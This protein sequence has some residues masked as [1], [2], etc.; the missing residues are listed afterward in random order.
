LRWARCRKLGWRDELLAAGNGDDVMP[1]GLRPETRRDTGEPGRLTVRTVPIA[2]P[3]DLL[4]ALPD[5]PLLSWVRRGRGLVGWGEAARVT[6]TAGEDRFTA[7]EKWLR[8]LFEDVIAEDQ[9]RVP[10]TGPVAFGSFTFDP[11]SDGSVLIVP[12]VIAGRDGT[13]TAWL[14]TISDG[15]EPAGRQSWPGAAGPDEEAGQPA[16]VRS[17]STLRWHDGSLTAPEW[18]HAV[19]LA[20]G[21]I[22]SGAL[23]KVVLARDVFATAA[24]PIDPRVLLRRL[25]ARYPDCYTFAVDG[26]TGA[27]PEL[28]IRRQG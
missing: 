18:E 11:A 26:L 9:V 21:R 27:T 19:E 12:R 14:T 1:G 10:G 23:R 8:T 13:G 3:G 2:D 7:G 4:A 24:E 5:G 25:A 17:A 6:L 22:T 16:G 15:R 28:L 20:V